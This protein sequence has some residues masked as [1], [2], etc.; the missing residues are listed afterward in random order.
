LAETAISPA[1][2]P[3]SGFGRTGLRD[4]S[5]RL[6]PNKAVAFVKPVSISRPEVK[7]YAGH[8]FVSHDRGNQELPK[9][10]PSVRWIDDD[11]AKP[12]KRGLVGY[13]PGKADL[14]G[15]LD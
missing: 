15:C 6:A 3:G 11:V 12:G 5:H 10:F 2:Q 8:A 1:G 7:C 4:S 9:P 14:T 13:D